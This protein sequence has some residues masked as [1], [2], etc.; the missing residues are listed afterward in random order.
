MLYHS[1]WY[2]KALFI[3]KV[4]DIEK[5]TGGLNIGYRI[6][7]IGDIY[8]TLMGIS[9]YLCIVLMLCIHIIRR[10]TQIKDFIGVIL[11]S[12]ESNL[13]EHAQGIEFSSS[14]FGKNNI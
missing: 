2:I 1:L 11:Y 6:T 13:P 7:G 5:I 9:I 14:K 3:Y 4:I 8:S 12:T 10:S